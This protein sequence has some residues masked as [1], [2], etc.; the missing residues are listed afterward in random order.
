M[1]MNGHHDAA[2]ILAKDIAKNRQMRK[3]YLL[4]GS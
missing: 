3:Q 2:K 4:M 1:A